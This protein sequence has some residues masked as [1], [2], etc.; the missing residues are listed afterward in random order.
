MP[1]PTRWML[2]FALIY[3]VV[4]LAL[5]V[6][7]AMPSSPPLLAAL[8]PAYIHFFVVGWVTQLV[9]GVVFWMFPKLSAERPR[10]SPGLAWSTML[11]LNIGLLLR[12]LAEPMQALHPQGAWGWGLVVS[13]VLQWTA[14]LA[15]VANTWGRVR[16]R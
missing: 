8:G 7:M 2:R 12:A 6:T 16:E 5:G 13:A 9:M 10:G 3:L 11:L 4:A 14:A 15:F 1:T